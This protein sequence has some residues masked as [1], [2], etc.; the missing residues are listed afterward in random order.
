MKSTFTEKLR[1]SS[2]I[3]IVLLLGGI[4]S[5]SIAFN[6]FQK[7]NYRFYD[8]M[9]GLTKEPETDESI[10]ILDI[11]DESITKIGEWPWK[12]DILADVLIRLK[13]FGADRAVFDIEYL[14]PS[15]KAVD[16]KLN[17]ITQESFTRGEENINEI[18][19]DYASSIAN[20]TIDPSKAID[21]AETYM[22]GI[23]ECLSEM[24]KDVTSGFNKDND[25]YFARAIQFFGNTFLTVSTRDISIKRSEDEIAYVQ[26]RFLKDYVSDP[27]NYTQATNIFS[28]SEEGID[29]Q[30]DFVPALHRIITRAKGIGFTNVVVD[31]D[32][33]R[34]RVELLNY[35][36]GKYALQLAFSPLCDKLDV[37]SIEV[38]KQ[39]LIM[40]GALLPGKTERE[41]ISIPL[42]QHGRMI[43]N[44][45]HNYYTETFNHVP[46][47][48]IYNID[49]A[50]QLLP[51][52]IEKM[53]N[54][55]LTTLSVDD[56]DYIRSA[57]YF[58][59]EYEKI[60]GEK[61]KLLLKC[62]G[63]TDEGEAIRGGIS[64]EDY[65]NYFNMRSTYFQTMKEFAD[66]LND[67][68]N[69][70]SIP[71]ATDFVKYV[72]GY[73]DDVEILKEIFNGKFCLIGNSA[74]A[75][76]DLGATP[77]EKRYANLGTHANVINTILQKSFIAEKSSFYGLAAAFVLVLV[78]TL[79]TRNMSPAKKNTIGIAY[80]IIP[81]SVLAVL[82]IFFRIFIPPVI[83]SL[84][85]ISCYASQ[86]IFSFVSL[87]KDKKFL[88]TKFG[89]YVSPEVVKEMQKNPELAELGAQNKFMTALFSDV[90]TFSGFTE[91]LNNAVGEEQGAVE[92][93]KILSDY[94]GY[95][96]KAIMEQKGTVDKFVGDEI[97]SFFNAP[98]DD[99]EHAF[100][101]CVAGIRMLQAEARYNEENKDKLPL[102]KM[103][104]EPFY[105]HSRVGINT[106]YMAVGNMG[107]SDK[108]N[109]TVMGNAVNL[110]SRLEGTNKE[111]GSWIMCSDATW[112]EADSGSN[113]GLLI[114][115]KFDCVK[116]INVNKP[117][118]IHNILGL[119][120]EMPKEQIEAAEIFNEGIM[121]YLKGMEN[122][123]EKKDIEDIK[124]ALKYFEQAAK[125]YSQ[126]L[127][128]NVFI[129]RCRNFIDNG[130]PAIWDGVFTM[131]TK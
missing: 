68:Q 64:S 19:F 108:M 107:T 26:N 98:L 119:R 18:I 59:T 23:D 29:V 5:A 88:Q 40:K 127:S 53:I 110:A 103:T 79:I 122:P 27:N 55:N 117:V 1:K 44:W 121:H 43:I 71:E 123:Q 92:L 129:N 20:G 131:K 41:D 65:S 99:S 36:D 66:S 60:L 93:Q 89:A 118:Q 21:Y 85:V 63:F 95:L 101:S 80:I 102:N 91:T 128:S 42:D 50:E 38:K 13:E 124:K 100:H 75:S 86:A 76:T 125:C 111:Y 33:I 8:I 57:A 84:F 69:I 39:K 10:L 73:M 94:L 97:V 51:E 32:G 78:I 54:A 114:A 17:L 52:S 45:L 72:N 90:K 6:L 83:P 22:Q 25:D 109:Y 62:R 105:L 28:A 4:F 126:D 61:N 74:T 47:F 14:S 24:H 113:S 2:N 130:L 67:I 3:L 7:I 120:S 15:V 49:L 31:K 56:I 9:L 106:G 115:R 46:I 48:R 58:L 34:R 12:R 81:L 104:G 96:T 37:Q 70:Q 30:L 82:M 35:H 16:D 112:K 116:V 11:N 87:E 77:F